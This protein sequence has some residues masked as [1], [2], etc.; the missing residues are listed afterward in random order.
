MHHITTPTGR[1]ISL[2]QVACGLVDL[3]IIAHACRDF[4]MDDRHG[5]TDRMQALG[6]TDAIREAGNSSADITPPDRELLV[7]EYNRALED[8]C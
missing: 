7:E 3:S 1:T 6:I 5:V 8:R 2:A 4:A